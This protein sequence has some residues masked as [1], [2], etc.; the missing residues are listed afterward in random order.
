MKK[1]IRNDE[2]GNYI[3]TINSEGSFK[4]NIKIKLPTALLFN[5][6]INTKAMMERYEIVGEMLDN[7]KK[8]FESDGKLDGLKIK[9]EFCVEWTKR[10]DDIMKQKS[11]FDFVPIQQ[12]DFIDRDDLSWSE[13]DFLLL[14]TEE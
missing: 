14:M 1:L 2:L 6:R 10:F 12:K 9:E 3:R 13:I 7:L 4:N 8:E 11:E 5:V